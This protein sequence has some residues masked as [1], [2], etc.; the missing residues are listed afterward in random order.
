MSTWVYFQK[1]V[2]SCMDVNKI[3]WRKKRI[4]L[5]WFPTLRDLSFDMNIIFHFT[6]SITPYRPQISY[7]KLGPHK[8]KPKIS[9]EGRTVFIYENM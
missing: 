7:L 6:Y 8:N 1:L 3:L 2:S 9:T 5:C 4:H